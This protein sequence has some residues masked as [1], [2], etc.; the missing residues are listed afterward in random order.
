MSP[1]SLV[2]G[3]SP[4]GLNRLETNFNWR[5]GFEIRPLV[6]VIYFLFKC[7]K[8]SILTSNK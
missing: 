3:R 1:S 8:L 4:S 2:V 6:V 7:G 5:I